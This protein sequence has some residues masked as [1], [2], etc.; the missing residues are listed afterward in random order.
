MSI[1]EHAPEKEAM[2]YV[3]DKTT[4][5][6]TLEI[7][8]HISRCDTCRAKIREY[9]RKRMHACR[10]MCLLFEAARA[11][12]LNPEQ[13]AFW[14]TH[15]LLCDQCLADYRAY[16]DENEPVT[17]SLYMGHFTCPIRQPGGVW[18]EHMALAAASS[19]PSFDRGGPIELARKRLS[20]TFI[21]DKRGKFKA[22]VESDIY[23]RSGV[24]VEVGT[25][26][27]TGFEVILS[28]VTGGRGVAVLG[29]ASK[30]QSA[31]R[32]S[33]AVIVRGLR[34]KRP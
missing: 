19:E 5:E 24:I 6:N 21:V 16:L 33:W 28:G 17:L 9:R 3:F 13:G 2:L 7:E 14:D 31:K 12:T 23:D 27:R 32:S 22:Y 11:D 1:D 8:D 25:K 34:K 4:P 30:L 29:S 20:T 26:R 15:I 10:Q 18:E